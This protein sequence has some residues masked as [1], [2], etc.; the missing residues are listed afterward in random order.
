MP[1]GPKAVKILSAE[2]LKDRAND[3]VKGRMVK[4]GDFKKK[5]RGGPETYRHCCPDEPARLKAMHN[6]LN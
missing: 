5:K 3:M 4:E 6:R 2:E 1:I